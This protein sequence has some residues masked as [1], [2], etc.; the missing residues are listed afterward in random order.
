[1]D[2]NPKDR[3]KIFVNE[4]Q[5]AQ[6]TFSLIVILYVPIFLL[7]FLIPCGMV[8]MLP[9]KTFNL[10]E[11]ITVSDISEE[12]GKGNIEMVTVSIIDLPIVAYIAFLI[13]GDSQVFRS[14]EAMPAQINP[15]DYR[16]YGQLQMRLSVDEAKYV[17]LTHSGF[18]V[19]IEARGA[20]VLY[21][22]EGYPAAGYLRPGDI[23]KEIGE[24]QVDNAEEMQEIIKNEKRNNVSIS[25]EREGKTLEKQIDIY[26]RN[27]EAYLGLSIQDALYYDFPV[28]IEVNTE[29][30][31]GPSAGLAMTLAMIDA[32]H[33][34]DIAGGKKIVATGE[35]NHDGSVEAIG[36]I[37]QK[38]DAALSADADIFFYPKDN[39][40]EVR[41]D[42][43]ELV[44]VAV[45]RVED[46]LDYL[47][48]NR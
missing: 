34:F 37:E 25:F 41:R 22:L 31:G 10:S 1:M 18:S 46:A 36:G 21:S 40:D 6:K 17:A 45:E 2:S 38:I 42:H 48:E 35:I 4:T 9:G 33:S 14:K 3:K 20:L 30:V 43:P 15:D 24:R 44:L 27:D 19:E 11:L 47:F 7:V 8:G 29:G 5:S 13:I 32:L 26:K 23:I 28:D 12:G 39:S 16:D